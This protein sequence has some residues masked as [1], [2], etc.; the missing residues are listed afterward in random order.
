MN[1]TF[2]SVKYANDRA[3][4][5][6]EGGGSDNACQIGRTT[7]HLDAGCRARPSHLLFDGIENLGVGARARRQEVTPAK[8]HR[9]RL[10]SSQICRADSL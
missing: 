6:D 8:R 2:E 1:A 10:R 7:P 5:T 3:E 9:S 4:E